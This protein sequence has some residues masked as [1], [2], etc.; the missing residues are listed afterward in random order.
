MP[1]SLYLERDL[2]GKKLR[3]IVRENKFKNRIKPLKSYIK[4]YG[5]KSKNKMISW[6]VNTFCAFT[7]IVKH[8]IY[9]F[10]HIIIILLINMIWFLL[11]M[12]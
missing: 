8:I 1:L 3:T 4:Y 9:I 7:Y 2:W 6:E 11:N 5:G 10:T 12:T